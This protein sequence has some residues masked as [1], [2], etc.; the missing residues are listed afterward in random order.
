MIKK[1]FLLKIFNAACMQRWN[2]K[3]RPIEL[4]E[5][6][7]QAHKMMIAYILGKMEENNKKSVNWIGIIEGGIYE[8]MLRAA[9]TDIK[10]PVFH[11][12]EKYPNHYHKMIDW[13]YKVWKPLIG[14][15]EKK[16]TVEKNFCNYHNQKKKNNSRKILEASHIL[17]T[18]W[19]YDHL[20]RQ[21]NEDDYERDTIADRHNKQLAYCKRE[22]LYYNYQGLEKLANFCGQLRFQIRWAHLHRVPRTSVLGH[23]LFVAIITYIMSLELGEKLEK[24]YCSKRHYNN[25]FTAL[26]HDLP[27]ALTRDI[28]SPVKKTGIDK[29]IKELEK[30]EM[31]EKIL[32]CLPDDAWKDE[33]RLFTGILNDPDG[34][35]LGE[36]SNVYSVEEKYRSLPDNDL[37][38]FNEDANKR[39]DGKIVMAADHLAAFIEAF[40][41]IENGCS[42]RDLHEALYRLKSEFAIDSP[43]NKNYDSELFKLMHEIYSEF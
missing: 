18:H 17:A 35:Q 8:Y 19:E 22:G 12:I 25:F 37:D 4:T 34:K 33:I 40:V 15:L 6:D 30:S 38:N 9:L 24:G 39:R 23:L 29:I 11:N 41:A 26:F 5:M 27:E 1:S 43:E 7:K 14:N 32:T 42:S 28:I 13:A 20:L 10:P 31:D 16:F 3:L 36:F 21:F 2:D